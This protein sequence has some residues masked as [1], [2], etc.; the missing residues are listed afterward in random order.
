MSM[1]AMEGKVGQ[2][3]KRELDRESNMNIDYS[4]MNI[5]YIFKDYSIESNRP[6]SVSLFHHQSRFDDCSGLDG[7]AATVH[8]VHRKTLQYK[9][10]S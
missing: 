9:D 4:Y 10:E 6:S 5:L 3:E 1:C 8:T 7:K 2:M